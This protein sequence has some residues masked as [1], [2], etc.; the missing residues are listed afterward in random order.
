MVMRRA[1]AVQRYG[2]QRV[3]RE[4]KARRWRSVCGV[5]VL[6]N[7]PPSWEERLA[8]AVLSKAPGRAAVD[9]LSV[10]HLV[11]V[12]ERPAKPQI[13]LP[14]GARPSLIPG[15]TFR[16]ISEL[17]SK[18]TEDKWLLRLTCSHA[19]LRALADVTAAPEARALVARA[20]QRKAVTPASLRDALGPKPRCRHAA[21]V[22]EVAA[23]FEGG[24]QSL[25]EKEFALII[26]RH[27]FPEPTRQRRV[28]GADGRYYLDSDFD[29]YNFSAEI[30]GWH[31]FEFRQRE[32]DMDRKNDVVSRGRRMLEFSSWAVRRTPDRVAAVLRT[33]LRSAGWSG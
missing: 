15:V 32:S 20:L 3:W 21:L 24:I 22:A 14:L 28:L 16:W 33:T 29:G 5:V 30:H 23:D 7:G 27:G 10:L 18:V 9:G 25:P 6:H 11:D 17:E 12:A 31:H 26:R 4:L 8:V 19:L 2:E 13:A 1:E